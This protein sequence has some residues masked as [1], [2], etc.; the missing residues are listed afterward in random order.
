MK[1]FISLSI[2][3][4]I[5]FSGCGEKFDLSVFDSGKT[6]GNVTGDTVYIKLSPD[7]SG[8]NSPT[9]IIIGKDY[10]IYVTDTGNDRLLMLNQ[11]GDQLS[12]KTLP[13][14]LKVEQ[15]YQL[16]LIV[17]GKFD[18]V[19][20]GVPRTMDAVYK[21]DMVAGGH[22]LA[23]AP[24][25]RLLPKP[26]SGVSDLDLR[27]SYTGISV[28]YNNSFY[29]ARTG[30]NN[31]SVVNPDN[32]IL[33]YQKTASRQDTLIG[34]LPAIDPNGTRILSANGISSLVG[35]DKKN[36]DFIL[37]L[38]GDNSFRVQWLTYV[39]SSL[40]EQYE[41]KLSPSGG[42]DLMQINKF[43]QPA[44]VAI[45]RSG[46]MYVADIGKDSVYRFNSFGG[47][48]QKFGGPENFSQ[49]SG[50]THYD[51][52]L[53]VVDKLNGKIVRYRLSTDN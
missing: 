23:S 46:N 41:L 9:D 31:T 24:V 21:I 17:I 34:R 2:L 42:S 8:F 15:D 4:L 11:N 36:I 37:T 52:V 53:F 20:N 18:T 40:G 6:G 38:S 44:D 39:I 19:L 12:S 33:S 10:F 50:L 25:S 30:P 28:F 26:G 5:A 32:S 7:W 27:L 16:N 22:N 45:D 13:K 14:P 51:R 35:F 29:I 49:P 1:K 3:A 48:L 47:Q 43:T